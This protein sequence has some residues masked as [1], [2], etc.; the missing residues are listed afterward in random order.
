ME[1]R[2]E[3]IRQWDEQQALE[4]KKRRAEEN[5][6]SEDDLDAYTLIRTKRAIVNAD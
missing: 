3:E 2:E 6:D 1:A 4:E 5:V